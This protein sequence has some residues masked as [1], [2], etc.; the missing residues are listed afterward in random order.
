L[1]RV[2]HLGGDDFVVIFHSD[3]WKLECEQILKV[4]EEQLHNYFDDQDIPAQGIYSFDKR[5]KA[6]FF[7][8]MGLPIGVVNSDAGLCN[9]HHDVSQVATEAKLIAGVQCTVCFKAS[10]SE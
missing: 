10:M 2:G 7:P 4:F 3:D 6:E 1:G 9:S 5:S 8:L